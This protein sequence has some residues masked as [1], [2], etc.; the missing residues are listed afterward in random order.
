VRFLAILPAV[1]PCFPLSPVMGQDPQTGPPAPEEIVVTVLGESLPLSVNP[2]SVSVMGRE[3]I[4]NSGAANLADLLRL[5]P[6]LML[7]RQGGQGGAVT[8]SIRGGEPNHTL[9]MINGVP[10]NDLTG[11]LGGAFDFTSLNVEGIAQVEVVRGPVSSLFGSEAMGGVVNVLLDRGEG[12]PDL[13]VAGALGGFGTTR[14]SASS[15]G[16]R[17]ILGY[18]VSG[19]FLDVG[20]QIGGDSLRRGTLTGS[21]DLVV[22]SRESLRF[23]GWFSDV[24][25]T[26]FPSNGGGPEESILRESEIRDSREWVAGGEYERQLT[27]QWLIA[28]RG[29]VFNR[30]LDSS[31]PDILD[32]IPPGP[33]S[34]PSSRGSSSFRRVRTTAAATGRF[35][36][37]FSGNL[38][39][40]FKRETGESDYLLAGFLPSGLAADRNTGA[41]S[42][43]LVLHADRLTGSVSTRLDGGT[44]FEAELSSR[45]GLAVWLSPDRCW[46]LRGGWGEGFKLPSFYS[47]SE[48]NIGNPELR[49]EKSDAWEIGI[50]RARDRGLF[51]ALTAFRNTFRDPIDFSPELFKLVN[52]SRVVAKGAELELAARLAHNLRLHGQISHVEPEIDG[53][54][55]E[56]RDRP[57]WRGEA[58]IEWR[59][60][61]RTVVRLDQLWVGRR[62]DFAVPVSDRDAVGGYA[63][64]TLV[65]SHRLT[66]AVE[67][68]LRADNLLDAEYLHFI[69][70][71]DPGLYV[72]GGLRW[73]PLR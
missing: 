33:R 21:L 65:V 36:D 40:Q 50:E 42:G 53:S 18:G 54:D 26:G 14:V 67:A 10:V 12:R 49:P 5:V 73:H 17:G 51:V 46:R 43:E 20:V 29:D 63:T 72:Q 45:I 47:L 13:S 27:A 71:R 41:F 8:A 57:K 4:R 55:E 59:P 24:S 16:R 23:T 70:F 30:D 64:T 60:G 48:P 69:G 15:A 44:D 61:G 68:F 25:A 9:V 19:A 31:T 3:E 7:T 28:L 6:G 1:L 56:L 32:G 2:A 39:V 22:S 35:N 52:R 38:G 58:G 34:V 11:Q 66:P 62:T 37:Y